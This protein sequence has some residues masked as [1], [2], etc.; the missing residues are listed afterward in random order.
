M[1]KRGRRANQDGQVD[2]TPMIDVVFQLII[3]FIVTITLTKESNKDIVMVL[4]PHAQEIVP[5]PQMF[6][7]EVDRRGW[8]SMYGAQ[9]SK[10]KLRKIMQHRFNVYGNFP[11]MIRGDKDTQHR[12]IRAVMD[13]CTEI[14]I[15]RISFVAIKE[16]KT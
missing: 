4:A 6:V 10:D 2:L 16:K 5:N 12:N 9:L 14:G 13:I 1:A 11:V 15:W 8:I 3:F 7:I